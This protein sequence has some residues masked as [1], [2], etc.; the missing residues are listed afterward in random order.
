M[1]GAVLLSP[2]DPDDS[3]LDSL[4]GRV[5]ASVASHYDPR[6]EVALTPARALPIETPSWEAY[7]EYLQGTELF[8]RSEFGEAARRMLGAYEIDPRF[9]KAAFFGALALSMDGQPAA[10]DSVTTAVMSATPSLHPYERSF[11]EWL[12]ADLHGRRT[13]A[14]RAGVEFARLG[15]SPQTLFVAGREALRMNRPREAVRV[16]QGLDL[17]R[18]WFRNWTEYFEVLRGALHVMGD[19]RAELSTALAGRARFP[20]SLVL[21]RTKVGARA[22]L[23]RSDEV[24]RLVDEALTLPPGETTS[25]EVA[26]VAAREL[27]AHGGEGAAAE[28]RRRGLEWL[29][30]HG[31]EGEEESL[32]GAWLLFESGN[33]EEASRRLG[34][35]PPAPDVDWLGLAGLLAARCGDA[36][37]AEDALARLEAWRDPYASGRHL[38]LAAG[39]RAALGQPDLSVETLRRALAAGLPFG[40]EL[41]AS[42]IL[43]PLSGRKDFVLLMRPRE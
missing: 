28:A 25:A 12:L 11:G 10:A 21:I 34:A 18:G 3:A 6:F 2:E 37:A 33:L 26:R 4:V 23:G 43:R 16:L 36:A 29:A 42:A 15:P 24:L 7:Q 8:G 40:V 9:V 39:I 32:L 38:F 30:R 5:L 17:E 22:A 27:A 1:P 20:G 35:P 13:D 14:Y 31:G 41:H 19:H